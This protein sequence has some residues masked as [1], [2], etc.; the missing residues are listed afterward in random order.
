[1]TITIHR[2]G[3]LYHYL[4]LRYD[5]LPSLLSSFHSALLVIAPLALHTP[6][7]GTRRDWAFL[8]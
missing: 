8:Q 3:H 6:P 2:F 1:M 4:L 7:I 5:F